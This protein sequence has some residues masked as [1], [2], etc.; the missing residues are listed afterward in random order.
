[1]EPAF[2]DALE[3]MA[4][5]QARRRGFNER[6][7]AIQGASS[8]DGLCVFQCECALVGCG[9]TIKLTA[10][11]YADVRADPR[12]FAVLAAHVVPDT[13]TVVATRRGWV[14]VEKHAGP[15]ARPHA[16]ERRRNVD[17]RVDPQ[18]PQR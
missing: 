16:L 18:V 1:V 15:G 10:G 17:A 6:L 9:A 14:V 2:D 12:H 13:E 8:P 3:L 5:S 11:E 4:R 7:A